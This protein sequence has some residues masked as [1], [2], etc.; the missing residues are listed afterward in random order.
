ML[1]E[2]TLAKPFL[3]V[4]GSSLLKDMAVVLGLSQGN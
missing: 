3:S 4:I 1:L 2:L